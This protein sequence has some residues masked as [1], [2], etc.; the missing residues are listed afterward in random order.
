MK[1]NSLFKQTIL[2]W[3]FFKGCIPIR[4]PFLNFFSKYINLL[5]NVKLLLREAATGGVLWKKVFLKISQNSQEN[6]CARFSFLIKLQASSLSAGCNHDDSL[7]D[8][9]C[10]LFFKLKF[11]IPTLRHILYSPISSNIHG[12]CDFA[13]SAS[14]NKLG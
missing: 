8:D 14:G 1:W 7:E 3:T 10:V 13:S 11:L 12:E 4:R 2:L 9:C 5:Q 6:T